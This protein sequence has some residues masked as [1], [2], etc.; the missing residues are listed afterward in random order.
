MPPPPH[1]KNIK[2]PAGNHFFQPCCR[3]QRHRDD[4]PSPAGRVPGLRLLVSGHPGDQPHPESD[5]DF[6]IVYVDV[7]VVIVVVIVN[8]VS[9]GV[10]VD[11]DDP[12]SA[13]GHLTKPDPSQAAGAGPTLDESASEFFSSQGPEGRY[14]KPGNN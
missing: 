4:H 14:G 5:V 10:D 9:V 8:N 11:D 1:K 6:I 13:A 7:V 3:S 12:L 2:G